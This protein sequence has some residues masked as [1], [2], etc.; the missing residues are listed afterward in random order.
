MGR[1][2]TFKQVAEPGRSQ[3]IARVRAVAN[4]RRVTRGAAVSVVLAIAGVG[5]TQAPAQA[6]GIAVKCYAPNLYNAGAG[7]CDGYS[8]PGYDR[9]VVRCQ[10]HRGVVSIMR[11]SWHH[12][13]QSWWRTVWCPGGYGYRATSAWYEHRS[14]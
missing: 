1:T 10:G 12:R 5:V 4:A 9:L 7:G 6:Q 13:Y 3:R 8:A 2:S 11:G 14:L